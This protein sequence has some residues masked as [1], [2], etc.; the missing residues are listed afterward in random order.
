MIR[1]GDGAT[2][3]RERIL[4]MLTWIRSFMPDGVSQKDVQVHMSLAHGL[5]YERTTRYLMEVAMAGV[6]EYEGGMIK[7]DEQGFKK[8]TA[9]LEKKALKDV[10][11]F[12]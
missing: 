10:S 6:V 7:V 1:T 2:I 9:A 8:L 11:K 3:R 12:L 4:E 5:T